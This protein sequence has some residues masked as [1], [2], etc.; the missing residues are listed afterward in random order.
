MKSAADIWV[1]GVCRSINP[2]RSG[3][4]YRCSTP[5]EVAAAKPEDLSI[6]H[7]EAPPVPTGV[8]RSSEA[9]AVAV[10]VAT[11]AF[12]LSALIAAWVNWSVADL[13]ASGEQVPAGG[14]LAARVPLLLL[15]AVIGLLALLSYAAWIRRVVENLSGLGVGYSRV[16]PTWAFFEPLIPGFNF[17]ALPARMA[18]VIQ[19]LG[20]HG[21]AIPLLGLALLIAI[22]PAVAVLY[23]LRFTR[24]FVTVADFLRAGGALVF[25]MLICQAI[26]LL[27]G[28]V[29]LWQIEGLCRAKMANLALENDS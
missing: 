5:I 26:A 13:R 29:V 24:W 16:S 10:S 19:K 7:R 27:I 6:T 23:V 20:G 18:E 1:C 12:I 3:K 8:V 14:L 11:V 15:G 28:L 17:Y 22:V 9:R 21:S 4:C 2:L 25:V